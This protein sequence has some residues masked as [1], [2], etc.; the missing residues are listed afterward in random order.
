MSPFPAREPQWLF[1]LVM[2]GTIWQSPFFYVALLVLMWIV[3]LI[4]T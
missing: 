1:R 3:S 2:L 4:S